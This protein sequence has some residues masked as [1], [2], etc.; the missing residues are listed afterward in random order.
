M[1]VSA[2]PDGGVLLCTLIGMETDVEALVSHSDGVVRIE[3]SRPS[4]SQQR[5]VY[6]IEEYPA[7]D[8]ALTVVLPRLRLLPT[9]R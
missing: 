7:G 8:P 3:Y 5:R 2:P 1:A 6:L 4:A 9:A